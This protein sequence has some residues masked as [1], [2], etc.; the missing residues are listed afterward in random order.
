[1]VADRLEDLTDPELLHRN[2]KCNRT[3]TLYG[4][5]R[6]TNMKTGSSVHIPGV[7]D[8]AVDEISILN[9]P[10]AIP[11]KEK[12]RLD[13][14][15]KLIYAPMSDVG[16]LIY[17]KDAVYINVPGNFTKAPA[18]SDG[19]D[20]GVGADSAT[21]A[22]LQDKGEKMVMELQ[23]VDHSLVDSLRNASFRMFTGSKPISAD[24]I[25]EE[26]EEE[27]RKSAAGSAD[28]RVNEVLEIDENGRRRR[29]ALFTDSGVDEADR[30]NVEQG[31]D[32]AYAD[33]DSDLGNLSSD[34]E[35]SQGVRLGSSEEEEE[36]EEERENGSGEIEKPVSTFDEWK[37]A[38][39]ERSQGA[40]YGRKRVNLMELVY[41]SRKSQSN[42]ASG[43]LGADRDTSDSEG[44]GGAQS[45]DSEDFFK[46][47]KRTKGSGGNGDRDDDNDD[48]N[49][50]DQLDSCK[51]GLVYDMLRRWD[52]TRAINAI[53][54]RFITGKLND[55]ADQEGEGNDA[56][57]GPENSDAESVVYGDF[58]DLEAGNDDGNS[59]DGG[60]GGSSSSDANEAGTGTDGDGDEDGEEGSSAGEGGHSVDEDEGEDDALRKKKEQLKRQFDAEY[61]DEEDDGPKKN[62]YEDQKEGIERQLQIN[63]EE[64]ED[65]DPELRA[66]VE[67]Y[68]PGQYV[69]ML[70]HSMPCEMVENFD[71][72][73]PIIVGGLL[74]NESN[75]GF[76]QVRIKRHRWHKKILKTNDPLILSIGWRRF[77]TIPTY[78]LSDRIKTRMLKYTPE[79]MH[80]LA[81]FYGPIT[82]PNTGFCAVQ[83]TSKHSADF[84]ISATGVVLDIDQGTEIVK[85]LKLTGTP[86]KILKNS[87]FIKGMF[88]SPLEVAKF[89][90]AQIRTVSGIRGQVKKAV[91]SPPGAFRATFE[92]KV[93]MSDIVF[94]KAWYPVKPKKFYNPVTSLLLKDKDKWEGMRLSVQIRRDK[95]I[96]IENNVD[97]HYK[98][99]ERTARRFNPLQVPRSLQAELP[100][101]SKPKNSTKKKRPGLMQR[102]AVLLEPEE[103]RVVDLL[104]QINL[105]SKEQ[106]MKRKAKKQAEREVYLKRKSKEEAIDQEHQKRRR[107]EF[108]K[109]QGITTL[110]Q[111]E[112]GRKK[113]KGSGDVLD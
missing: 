23:D 87:A 104:N 84:R 19:D 66:Q 78:A 93:L 46:L 49:E 95:G 4:Y 80:C 26:E 90:G 52:D 63:R 113:S 17:D 29:R 77:Q 36:D 92:D 39:N 22:G 20:A 53:R 33:T 106:T 5:L 69:R 76:V 91:S 108:Y 14:R 9:D 30:D 111:T 65:D 15:H 32:I 8:Y 27:E 75:F 43:G 79:H 40:F 1:M 68:R 10:C 42:G 70:F 98:P 47:R 58:E 44:K 48:E 35:E 55:V 67:G 3:I 57:E 50:D 21:Q 51:A 71:P 31:E 85:K 59:D 11:D 18:I 28:E 83:S 81:V 54:S 2:P 105:L 62:F 25:I 110:R 38:M 99:I 45:D 60:G 88:N 94:L 13:E 7:G 12:K 64:F 74:P 109:A 96:P 72:A 24:D 56:E 16:G 41:G 102:R 112:A 107:K 103:R 37:V 89:E 73:Y 97:S 61:D 86:Y 100:Y 82:A 34:E 6:G 101:A